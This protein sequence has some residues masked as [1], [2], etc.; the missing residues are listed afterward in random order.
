MGRRTAADAGFD[1]DR[2]VQRS[3]V[4]LV[5]DTH[6][7]LADVLEDLVAIGEDGA[8]TA[9]NPAGVARIRCR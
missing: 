4:R 9:E 3:I 7:A 8:G 2:F 1:G 5:D 6:P